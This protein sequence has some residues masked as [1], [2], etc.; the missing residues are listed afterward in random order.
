MKNCQAEQLVCE[1][2]QHLRELRQ[3][4]GLSHETLAKKAGISRPAI[5]H[6]EN[7]KR[8]P[9]LMVCIKLANALD[10]TLADIM[11]CN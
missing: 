5:S 6:I 3:K 8:K 11:K 4:K 9:S 7:G 10:T 2:V 1:I